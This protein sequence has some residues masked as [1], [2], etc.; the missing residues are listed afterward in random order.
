MIQ[1][2]E[3]D[4]VVPYISNECMYIFDCD[5]GSIP[6]PCTCPIKVTLVVRE[7]SVVQFDSTRHRWFT[8]DTAVSSSYSNTARMR[9]GPYWISKENSLGS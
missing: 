3:V 8:P 6:V 7:K 2:D 5:Q 1:I 4:L 9:G